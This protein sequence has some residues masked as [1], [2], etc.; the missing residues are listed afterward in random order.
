MHGMC[1]IRGVKS[2]VGPSAL[3]QFARACSF[4]NPRCPAP[5]TGLVLM[6][7]LL[8]NNELGPDLS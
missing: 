6:A 2:A 4:P 8:I 1:H 3:I 7:D 5:S